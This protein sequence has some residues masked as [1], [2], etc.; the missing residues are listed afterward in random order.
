MEYSQIE[1]TEF[2]SGETVV[3]QKTEFSNYPHADG[4]TVCKYTIS[5]NITGAPKTIEG[6]YADG[7]WTFT[8]TAA[9]NTLGAGDAFLYGFVEKGSGAALERYPIYPSTPLTVGVALSSGTN[10]DLR[11]H[12]QLMLDKIETSLEALATHAVNSVEI[13]GRSYTRE[14]MKDLY[15]L[16]NYYKRNIHGNNFVTIPVTFS[17][18]E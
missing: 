8:L 2:R 5:G 9:N 16:R 6:V 15:A 13:A 10:A 12:D 14:N 18:G 11:T 4:F 3:W 7:I 1:P 17:G